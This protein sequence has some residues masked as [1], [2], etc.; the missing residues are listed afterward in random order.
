MLCKKC[1][2][3][4]IMRGIKTIV[5]SR[6]KKDAVISYGHAGHICNNCSD[7]TNVCMNCSIHI[8]SKP[9]R[10]FIYKLLGNQ[11]HPPCLYTSMMR[12][13][14]NETCDT[15]DGSNCWKRFIEH[16]WRKDNEEE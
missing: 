8:T 10:K 5:C 2:S 1:R 9:S 14:C 11:N 16:M 15:T 13:V 12:G 6:C 7:E 3:K 4:P